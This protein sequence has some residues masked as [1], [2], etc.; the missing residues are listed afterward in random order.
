MFILQLLLLVQMSSRTRTG[1]R[2]WRPIL[3]IVVAIFAYLSPKVFASS[4]TIQSLT[5]QVTEIEINSFKSFMS[6]ESAPTTNTYNNDFADGTSGME[7]EALGMMYEVTNDLALLNKMIVYADDFLSLRNDLTPASEGGQRVMW[8]GNIDPVWLTYPTN[9]SDSGYAGC[10]NND[11]VGHIAYCAKLILLTPL[12]WS[13]T[14]PDGNPHGYG[15][16]YYQRATNYIAQ[17]EYSEAN[18]FNKYFINTSN[19]QITA[20]TS[21]AW[22]T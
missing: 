20:P 7:A 22:T 3:Q 12:L 11:I 6:G 15:A 4:M 21:S 2:Y 10:E 14:V 1:H 18:Y 16:T 9:V 8:D 13:T 5:G 19:D 17:M